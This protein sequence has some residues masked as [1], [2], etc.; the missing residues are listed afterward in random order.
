MQCYFSKLFRHPLIITLVIKFIL[1]FGLW[2]S[3]FRPALRLVP[4]TETVAVHF[5]LI[6]THNKE[7][8]LNGHHTN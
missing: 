7:S 2:F 3:F 1:L 8:S 4:H 5:G 6:T